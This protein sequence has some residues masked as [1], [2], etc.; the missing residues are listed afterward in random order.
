MT[1]FPVVDDEIDVVNFLAE[2]F[3]E[4]DYEVETAVPPENSS[5]CMAN[6]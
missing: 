3:T 1:R 4:R 6:Y 5:L 2:E